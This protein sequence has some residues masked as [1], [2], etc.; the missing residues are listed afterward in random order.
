MLRGQRVAAVAGA[1][2][3]PLLC[4]V[5]HARARSLSVGASMRGAQLKDGAPPAVKALAE[6]RHAQAHLRWQRGG[7]AVDPPGGCASDRRRYCACCGQKPP[8]RQHQV[9]P[10]DELLLIR[11][12]AGT[13]VC[14]DHDVPAARERESYAEQQSMPHCRLAR[15]LVHAIA[16]AGRTS[17]PR[18]LRATALSSGPCAS[19]LMASCY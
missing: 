10:R 8:N 13:G 17:S 4:C 1:G 19:A 3:G 14:R 9:G 5:P 16:H 11:S 18:H 6:L 2:S 7:S 15:L 12:A